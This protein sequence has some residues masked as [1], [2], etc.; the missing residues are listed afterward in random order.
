MYH[1]L[2]TQK[3]QVQVEKKL[4]DKKLLRVTEKIKEFEDEAGRSRCLYEECREKLEICEEELRKALV[5]ERE[6]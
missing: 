2:I 3:S 6:E 5:T 1:Q 4:A